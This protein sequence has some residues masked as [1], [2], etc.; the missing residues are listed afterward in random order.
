MFNKQKGKNT[1]A[2]TSQHKEV[3]DN[4]LFQKPLICLFD[5]DK[6]TTRAVE[7]A[8]FN[9][10]VASLGKP[11][12]VSDASRRNQNLFLLNRDWPVNLHEYDVFIVDMAKSDAIAYKE[13]EHKR[14]YQTNETAHYFLVEHPQTVFDG[15][16]YTGTILQSELNNIVDRRYILITFA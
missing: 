5:M 11:V 12:L 10:S 1:D 9:I 7:S 3:T 8:G 13:D 4:I 16:A 6:S 2:L 14:V 15:R